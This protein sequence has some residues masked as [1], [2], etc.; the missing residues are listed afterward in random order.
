MCIYFGYYPR[1]F[2]AFGGEVFNRTAIIRPSFPLP[3]GNFSTKY[4]A[5]TKAACFFFKIPTEVNIG[6]V[7]DEKALLSEIVSGLNERFGTNFPEADRLFFQQIHEK[8]KIKK[9]S[10]NLVKPIHTINFGF[11]LSQCSRNW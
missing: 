8:A 11:G 3:L 7:K 5:L 9:Q 2:C 6:K 4:A 1:F 10:L